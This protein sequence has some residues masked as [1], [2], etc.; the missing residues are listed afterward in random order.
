VFSEGARKLQDQFG[1]RRLAD[2][3]AQ[4][5][6][7]SEL[8]EQDREFIRG[9]SFFFL[10]TADTSGRP[11]CSYKGGL[12]GFVELLDGGHLAFPDFDG[13]GTFRSLGNIADNPHIALLFIDFRH[14]ERTLVEGTASV[15]SDAELLAR[16]QGAQL[17][18]VVR[19]TRAF[20]A[21]ARY[22]HN[23]EHNEISAFVP[24]PD[25]T[26]PVPAWK[27]K[28]IYQEVLPYHDTAPGSPKEN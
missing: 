7:R 15:A 28:P 24:R 27:E 4:V 22:V 6:A 5:E 16:W 2:R 20:S 21:C 3:L 19:V 25:H 1:T 12:P 8:T 14:G 10:A 26:V 9:C 18:I 13:N 23:L 11:L 17:A